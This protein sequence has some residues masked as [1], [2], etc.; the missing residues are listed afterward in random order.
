VLQQHQENHHVQGSHMLKM[1]VLS[2]RIGLEFKTRKRVVK[3]V[4]QVKRDGRKDKSS[5]LDSIDE[6]PI[7][8]LKTSAI[9]NKEREKLAVDPPT[10]KSEQKELK[11]PKI[12]RKSP[13]SRTE[14]KPSHPLGLSSW[15]RRNLQKLSA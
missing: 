1:T 6:K 8:V 9:N 12:K 4:Y 2:T 14:A 3:Q 5:D 7:N 13:L 10:A 11:K 15:Q